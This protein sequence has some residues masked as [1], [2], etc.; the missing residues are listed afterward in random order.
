MV[1]CTG[2]RQIPRLHKAPQD[3]RRLPLFVL[4][5]TFFMGPVR[6]AAFATM[7]HPGC[8]TRPDRPDLS[9][10]R[11]SLLPDEPERESFMAMQGD[12]AS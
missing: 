1:V 2:L 11:S 4:Q 9:A 3:I 10:V 6:I 5:I 7:F 8:I 12:H